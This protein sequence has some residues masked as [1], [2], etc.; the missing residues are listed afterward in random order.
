MFVAA[1]GETFWK[2]GFDSF[3][4]VSMGIFYNI[5]RFFTGSASGL[6]LKIKLIVIPGLLYGFSKY[7]LV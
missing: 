5:P 6:S 1:A 2:G 7:P 3:F 4:L